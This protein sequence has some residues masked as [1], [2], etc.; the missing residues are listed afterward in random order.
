L[1][2]RS[3]RLSIIALAALALGCG[4]SSDDV[5]IL[6]GACTF[7]DET[8]LFELDGP[9]LDGV[10]VAPLADGAYFAWS[11]R[12][13]LFGVELDAQAHARGD[14]ERLGPPCAGGVD[15]LLEG[16]RVLIACSA[17]GDAERGDAGAVVVYAR[18]GGTTRVLE[19]REGVGSDGLGVALARSGS[20]VAVGWQEAHGATSAAWVADVGTGAEP[21]RLSR[22]GFRA[23]APALVFEGDTL[24]A[25]WG[26]LWLDDDGDSVG[27]VQLQVG[28]RAPRPIDELAYDQVLPVLTP[29]DSDG[30]TG[31]LLAFRD[32]RP[33]GSRPAVMLARVSSSTREAQAVAGAPANAAGASVAVACEHAV[34]VVAPRTHSRTERL[35]SVRRHATTLEGMGPEQQLYEHAATFEWADAVCLGD[36]LLVVYGARSSPSTPVGSVRATTVD[37]E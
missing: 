4:G 20:G 3:V 21:R 31:A 28:H 13:G 34:M 25:V 37:C 5:H 19:R 35:V 29:D 10:A 32:R 24:L 17:R 33:A 14:R 36:R 2:V 7:G 6:A 30:A 26:E 16:D 22:G 9:T 1:S 8:R 27:R 11:E 15:A 23:S 12:A 18:E